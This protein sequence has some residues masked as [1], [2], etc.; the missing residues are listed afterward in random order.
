[1]P[2]SDVPQARLHDHGGRQRS[3]LSALHRAQVRKDHTISNVRLWWQIRLNHQPKESLLSL[4]EEAHKTLDPLFRLKNG[5]DAVSL[6]AACKS[7]QEGLPREA[8]LHSP[9]SPKRHLL[10]PSWAGGRGP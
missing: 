1:M 8:A 9:G 3:A 7:A 2:F 5:R 6:L 4:A 10:L